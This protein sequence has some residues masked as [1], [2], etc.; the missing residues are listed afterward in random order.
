MI[1]KILKLSVTSYLFS[2]MVG[3]TSQRVSVSLAQQDNKWLLETRDNFTMELKNHKNECSSELHQ[4]N[5]TGS[6]LPTDVAMSCYVIACFTYLGTFKKMQLLDELAQILSEREKK[7]EQREEAILE[8]EKKLEQQKQ[9]SELGEN[10]EAQFISQLYISS[11]IDENG[12]YVDTT[13]II[14]ATENDLPN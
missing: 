14:G 5:N 13:E 7:L 11:Y 1:G 8:R 6:F 3:S 10:L 12:K 4:D 2:K 9:R